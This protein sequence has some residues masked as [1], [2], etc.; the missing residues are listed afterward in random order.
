MKH[1]KLFE[2]YSDGPGTIVYLHGLDAV[3]GPKSEWLSEL[4]EVFAPHMDYRKDAEVVF[5]KL[6]RDLRG[7][8]VSLVI[9]SSMGGYMAYWLCKKIGAPGLLFNPALAARSVDV[10]VI[11]DGRY[12]PHFDVVLGESD[13]VVDPAR[14]RQWLSDN[15]V[16]AEVHSER[17]GH[18]IPMQ[19]F[20][21]YVRLCTGTHSPLDEKSGDVLHPS[22]D[23]WV[24]IDPKKHK[25]L[26]DEFFELISTAYA[27]IGGHSKIEKPDDVFSDP[28]WTF[29]KGVDVHGSPDLDL[30]VWGQ[31]TKYGV[32]FSGV[33]HDGEKDT[34]KKYLEQKAKD[35]SKLGFY[36]EVSG[37]LAE[38]MINKYNVPIVEDEAELRKLIPKMTEFYGKHPTDDSMP[39][40][41][42]YARNIGGHTHIKTVIG[43][44]KNI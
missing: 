34:K 35:L 42:W 31:N 30:I 26:S 41:G 16:D 15:G 39:G 3:P 23:R 1:I 2:N 36:N 27:D 29:W 18:K 6:V 13:D 38:I 22:K 21:K 8:N 25:E 4:G 44:P 24:K 7:V 9:G 19:V 10:G 20:Q 11:D 43:R 28:D 33:G 32:K 5:E 17:I 37:K 12:D 40:N 14:T